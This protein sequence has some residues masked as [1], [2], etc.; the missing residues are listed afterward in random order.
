MDRL[1]NSQRKAS[2]VEKPGTKPVYFTTDINTEVLQIGIVCMGSTWW[3]SW[4][5]WE[6]GFLSSVGLFPGR[7]S[8]D[9]EG[10]LC[11]TD[12]VNDWP[13]RSPAM[14]LLRLPGFR[15]G[16]GWLTQGPRNECK[17]RL[18]TGPW[19][20]QRSAHCTERFV[21]VHSKWALKDKL[22]L[23]FILVHLLHE[24]DA[25]T[26]ALPLPSFST[27][28]WCARA[29]WG[30]HHVV[31]PG[32][33]LMAVEDKIPRDEGMSSLS[34]SL[35][36]SLWAAASVPSDMHPSGRSMKREHIVKERERESSGVSVCNLES[37]PGAFTLLCTTDWR[38]Y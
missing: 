31:L 24:P 17:M 15:P 8:W 10:D 21:L 11:L 3:L 23:N 25:S 22:P 5:Q 37:W 29:A 7:I 28:A 35:S 38:V 30:A 2:R 1:C 33:D 26:W 9:S 13:R 34:P 16:R 6:N 12:D 14:F 20:T 32:L 4:G 36:S 18:W 19:V 27:T